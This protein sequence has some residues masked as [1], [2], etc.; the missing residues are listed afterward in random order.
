MDQRRPVAW[1]LGGRDDATLR[2]LFDKVGM[3]GK[4]FVTDDREGYHRVIPQAQL[5]TGK[6][7]TFPIEQDNSNV[8]HCLARCGYKLGD[9]ST[10][11]GGNEQTVLRYLQT[12]GLA[13]AD[14]TWQKIDAFFEVDPK[15]TDDVKRAIVAGKGLYLGISI[16]EAW[17]TGT[18]QEWTL[19]S[20]FA[21]IGGGHAIYAV[22]Y[23]SIGV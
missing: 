17:C 2:R 12:T 9:A 1:V 7:L 8:R 3:S 6:D 4:V 20:R 5:F 14:G 10:D 19:Q 18:S 21:K 22:A 11:Q 13:L 16:P 23:D 15:N